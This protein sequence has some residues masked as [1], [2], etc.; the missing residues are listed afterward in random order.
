ML[1][2]SVELFWKYYE[3]KKF[4]FYEFSMVLLCC[5]IE[6]MQHMGTICVNKY[7]I[8][9]FSVNSQNLKLNFLKVIH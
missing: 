8:I 3:Y 1:K 5:N 9:L 2:V 6:I 4:T 7:I